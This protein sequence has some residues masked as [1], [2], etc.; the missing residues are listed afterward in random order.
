[1]RVAF[2]GA[3]DMG[4][5]MAGH[6]AKAGHEL[7]VWNRTPGR[8]EELVE[9]GAVPASSPADAA[10][11][12][13]VAITMLSDD[14]AVEA[15]MSEGLLQGLADGAIHVSMSTVGVAAARRFERRHSESGQHFIAAPVFG[16]PADAAAAKLWIVAG[17]DL[18]SIERCRPLFD[19]MGQGTF[20]AGDDPAGSCAVKLA[21]NF[22]LASMIKSLGEAFALAEGAG[23]ERAFVSQVISTLFASPIYENY[24]AMIAARRY[25][26]GF[27]LRLGLRDVRLAIEAA[28]TSGVDTPLGELLRSE[29]EEAIHRGDGDLDWAALGR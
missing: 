28:E 29:L 6:L 18:T 2:L 21:G 17:G 25:E 4:L 14:A 3:G 11:S 5:P 26:P 9:I 7:R 27:K 10:S 8:T 22:L 16:R 15:V 23:V 13:E 20:V 19:V 24:G 12:A 1:M